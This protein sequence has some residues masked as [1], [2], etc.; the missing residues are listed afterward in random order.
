MAWQQV[1]PECATYLNRLGRKFTFD[2]AN[3]T[4]ISDITYVRTGEGWRYLAAVMDLYSSKIIGFAMASSQNADLICRALQMAISVRQPSAG[5][6]IHS[7]QGCQYISKLYQ[8][9]VE[10]YQLTGSMSRHGNC[11]ESKHCFDA[12]M[13]RFS[14][15]LK[16]ELIWQYCYETHQEARQSISDYI[17]DAY[18]SNRLHSTLLNYLS[19]NTF[20]ATSKRAETI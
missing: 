14:R 3:S 9:L 12:I 11:W 13:E 15:S 2:R 20:E 17:L 10:K 18:N 5:L 19:P 7:D 6:L 16:Q 1:S 4:W 8:A